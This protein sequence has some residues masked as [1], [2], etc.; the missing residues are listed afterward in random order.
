[1]GGLAF[2]RKAA[3]CRHVVMGRTG[4]EPATLGLKVADGSARWC[5]PVATK[6]TPTAIPWVKGL[7]ECT[8]DAGGRVDLL[9]TPRLRIAD[10]SGPSGSWH[11][12]FGPSPTARCL[13]VIYGYGFFVIVI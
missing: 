7:G 1:M 2:F 12:T 6:P 4:I 13:P 3:V 9:L 5:S 8:L 10:V 11:G